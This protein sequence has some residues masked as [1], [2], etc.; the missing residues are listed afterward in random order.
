MIKPWKETQ[1]ELK[2]H[3]MSLPSGEKRGD[4][5]ICCKFCQVIPKSISKAFAK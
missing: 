5:L 1:P 4:H 3:G 2:K